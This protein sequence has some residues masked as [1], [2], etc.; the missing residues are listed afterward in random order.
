MNAEIF[1]LG[2]QDSVGL[3]QKQDRLLKVLVQEVGREPYVAMAFLS[4]P[5]LFTRFHQLPEAH[6][7]LT[8]ADLIA[9]QISSK[10][11]VKAFCKSVKQ[12]IEQKMVTK[13]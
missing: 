6:R 1:T 2:S 9:L 7:L 12:S 8:E 3:L 5:H 4:Y 10:S 13:G 11:K